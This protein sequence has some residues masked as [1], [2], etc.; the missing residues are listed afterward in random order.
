MEVI[1]QL[2]LGQLTKSGQAQIQLTYCWDGQRLRVG[3][4]KSACPSTGTP[5]A[6]ASKL[7]CAYTSLGHG[8]AQE[9]GV[10]YQLH[11]VGAV[12]SEPV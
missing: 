6:S 7:L 1:C 11:N 4:G 12:A 8:D 3:A 5:S 2:R 9:L 10:S